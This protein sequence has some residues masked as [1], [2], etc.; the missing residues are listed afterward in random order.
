MSKKFIKK[1]KKIK[2][3]KK[4]SKKI[5]KWKKKNKNVKNCQKSFFFPKNRTFLKKLKCQQK[6]TICFSILGICDLTRALQSSPILKK[7]LE[8]SIFLI[9]LSKHLNFWNYSAEKNAILLVLPIEEIS[10]WPELS[11]PAH[12]RI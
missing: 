1:I 3:I 7:N 12:F 5:Q 11:S 6:N 9:L 8:K 4:K 10:L 2:N